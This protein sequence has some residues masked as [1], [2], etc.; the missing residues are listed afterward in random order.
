MS[1][2]IQSKANLDSLLTK[3]VSQVKILG[4][5]GD[6][7]KRV[8]L[9]EASK[10]P[11]ILR[12]TQESV[13]GSIMSLAQAGLVPD[14]VNNLAYL[15][16][17]GSTC[18]FIIGYKGLMKLARDNGITIKLPRLV[19]ENDE[20]WYNYGTEEHIHHTPAKTDPGEMTHAYCVAEDGGVTYL[21]VMR[22]DE[23]DKI[24]RKA[25]AGKKSSPW[26]SDYNEMAKKTVV[27]R[28]LKYLDTTGFI[29]PQ[30]EEEEPEIEVIEGTSET[31]ETVDSIQALEA[32]DEERSDKVESDPRD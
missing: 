26:L 12:C 23:I 18:G 11:A 31:L 19:Y 16:P 15:I 21:D 2:L 25:T 7:V 9:T 32:A 24:M 13:L 14:S 3:Q 5:N 28:L 20:F 30:D 17:R 29:P 8:V 22:R 10:N 4:I 6:L 27:R 1:Q